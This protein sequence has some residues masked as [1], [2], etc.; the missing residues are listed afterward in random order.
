MVIKSAEDRRRYDAAHVLDGARDRSVS[1]LPASLK[2]LIVAE[3]IAIK[4]LW[5]SNQDAN[6]TFN[7]AKIS[8]IECARA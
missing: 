6:R 4:V 8:S 7:R 3:S 5:V 1:V 2:P